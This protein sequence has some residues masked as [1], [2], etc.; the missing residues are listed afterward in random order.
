MIEKEKINGLFDVMYEEIVDRNIYERYYE[1][2]DGD[3]VVDIGAN[4]GLFTMSIMDKC[5]IKFILKI[6]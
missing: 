3:V 6:K 1:V 4:I 5:S 2:H